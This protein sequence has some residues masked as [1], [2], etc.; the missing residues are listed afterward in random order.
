VLIAI[1]RNSTESQSWH[2]I[3]RASSAARNNPDPDDEVLGGS[4][5]R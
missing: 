2:W 3:E 1:S 5:S 4:S